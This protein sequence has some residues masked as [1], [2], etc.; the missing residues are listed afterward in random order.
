MTGAWLPFLHTHLLALS[1]MPLAAFISLDTL[2]EALSTLGY[3]AVA[4]FI[5]IESTGI[6]FPGE[7][8]LLLASFYA[9]VDHR[10][11][12]PLVIACAAFGAI[13]GDNIGYLIGRTGGYALVQRFG[14]YVFLKPAHLQKAQRF[15]A[16][17]GDKTV[18]LGRFIAVLRAWAAFLAGVN[19]MPWPNFLFYNAA[20]GI[21][22]SIVYGC[23][24]FYA[25][26]IFHDNFGAV[27]QI[28]KTISWGGAAAIVAVIVAIYFL[29]RL[30]RKRRHMEQAEDAETAVEAASPET[31]AP[32]QA[33]A[34]HTTEPDQQSCP[35]D[36]SILP[37]NTLPTTDPQA[38]A[39]APETRQEAPSSPEAK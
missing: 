20:G 31:S 2:R 7:T 38:H 15:F 18:F 26:R 4:L 34:L 21:L 17:H 14:R 35:E 23:L 10:L 11:Q 32:L 3:P 25:G 36:N 27:E 1:D 19:H 33:L 39:A 30:R 6:P 13:V 9:A 28:A 29:L 8:M 5:M 16:R 12:I 24:G 37:T 22:W